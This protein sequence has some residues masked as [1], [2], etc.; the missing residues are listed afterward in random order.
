AR[1]ARELGERA[2]FR[3]EL[4]HP[5]DARADLAQSRELLEEL[6]RDP[7]ALPGWR[8][9]LGRAY[10][11]LSRVASGAG[12]RAAAEWRARAVT[13]LRRAAEDSPEHAQIRRSLAEA[14]A[15]PA[16]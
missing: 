13:A 4:T 15:A 14:E 3:L 6:M 10:L 11:G 5:A 2:V 8:A 9:D 1:W 16:K 7:G 12:D